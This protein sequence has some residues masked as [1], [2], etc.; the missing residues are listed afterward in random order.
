MNLNSKKKEDHS[1]LNRLVLIVSKNIKY[2]FIFIH[3]MIFGSW[4]M[5]HEYE[6]WIINDKWHFSL[7]CVFIAS[8]LT[9]IS[10]STII[11]ISSRGVCLLSNTEQV[12]HKP[13]H[14]F[15]TFFTVSCLLCSVKYCISTGTPTVWIC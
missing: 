5:N 12:N 11:W 7:F 10:I 3:L 15:D 8:P 13:H 9:S 1:H 2:S 14:N 6:K 4:S